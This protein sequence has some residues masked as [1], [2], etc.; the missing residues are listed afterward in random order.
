MIPVYDSIETTVAKG[1][2]DGYKQFLLFEQCFQE[3]SFSGSRSLKLEMVLIKGYFPFLSFL[4]VLLGSAVSYWERSLNTEAQRLVNRLAD[5][6]DCTSIYEGNYF[7][8]VNLH[9]V[10]GNRLYE[11][12]DFG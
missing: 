4:V 11:Y 10:Q 1:E 3:V 8:A 2:I 6:H 5:P 12:G 9:C 7:I